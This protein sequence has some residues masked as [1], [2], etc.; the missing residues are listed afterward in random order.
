MPEVGVGEVPILPDFSRFGRELQRG[1]E[2]HLDRAAKSMESTFG[3]AAKRSAADVDKAFSKVKVDL[4]VTADTDGLAGELR[5]E[6]D[7]IVARAAGEVPITAGTSG[8]GTDLRAGIAPHLDPVGID[9]RPDTAAFSR[10]P[11]EIR[12]HVDRAG[13]EIEQGF[14]ASAKGASKALIGAVGVG[15]VAGFGRELLD[16][17]NQAAVFREK[18]ATVFEDS[19]DD[20]RRWA[21]DN[22]A[23]LGLTETRLA[24]VAAGFADLLKPMGFTAAEAAT[25]STE[26]VELAGALSAWSAEQDTAADV[27]KVLG[28]AMLGERDALKGLGISISEADVAARLAVNGQQDLTGAA[29]QQ[30]EAI[31]TQQLIFEKSTDAQRAWSDG[32]FDAIKTQNELRAKVGEIVETM[33]EGLL[34]VFTAAAEVLERIPTPAIAATGALVG[35]GLAAVGINKA[36]GAIKELPNPLERTSLTAGVVVGALGKIGLAAGG[37]F[38]VK[39]ALDAVGVGASDLGLNLEK[40]VKLADKDLVRGFRE[41]RDVGLDVQG[42]NEILGQSPSQAQRLIDAL[43]AAGVETGKYRKLLDESI[44]THKAVADAKDKDAK[45]TGE[46]VE[47]VEELSPHTIK[48]REEM[49]AFA[50]TMRDAYGASQS[51]VGSQLSVQDAIDSLRDSAIESAAKERELAEAI[52]THGRA[53]AEAKV[54]GEALEDARRRQLGDIDSLAQANVRLAEIQATAAGRTLSDRDKYAL[55]RDELIKVKDTLAPDAPLRKHLQ[56]LIDQLPP[57]VVK[58]QVVIDTVQAQKALDALRGPTTFGLSLQGGLG[59]KLGSRHDGGMVDGSKP[60]K[61]EVIIKALA[62]EFVMQP[63]AVEA[64]GVP[65]L[66]RLNEFHTGGVVERERVRLATVFAPTTSAALGTL[67]RF[68]G[69]GIVSAQPVASALPAQAMANVGR[70]LPEP[71]STTTSKTFDVGG[72]NVYG[73]E[74]PREAALLTAMRLRSELFLVEG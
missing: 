33:A 62:G 68:H 20:V 13:D 14:A 52:R 37:I 16:L 19:A 56:G 63:A 40:V 1:I 31:A 5:R 66:E 59:G 42:F 12:P 7:P 4:P 28:D 58:S 24:G 57:P 32:S 65:L 17:G 25:M 67:P 51:L 6:L 70:A 35:I 46:L 44:A 71:V 38:A 8:F 50:A 45:I 49:D 73:V 55:Y 29:L 64:L 74:D 30:A 53:S 72:I 60:A 2:P 36:V 26:T 47:K 54:A 41:L 39:T 34:P 11:A 61:D 43:D 21:K 3:T 48:A 15:L 9:V 18:T 27:A 23:S 22:A 69:G 10:L